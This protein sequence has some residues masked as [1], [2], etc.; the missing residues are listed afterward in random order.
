MGILNIVL[1]SSSKVAVPICDYLVKFHDLKNVITGPDKPKGRGRT[2]TANEFATY[3]ASRGLAVHKPANDSELDTLIESIKPDLVVT[4][5]YGRLIKKHQ[6]S[7]PEKGWINVHFSVLPKWRGAAPVQFSILNGDETSGITVF[8]LDTGLDTGPV[9]ASLEHD[10]K[11][12][13]TSGELLETLSELAIQPLEESLHKITLG[14]D[15]TPQSA[16]GISLAPKVSKNDGQINWFDSNTSIERRVRALSPW[17]GAWSRLDGK[18]IHIVETEIWQA[19]IDKD[20]LPGSLII[21]SQIIAVCG[22]GALR[23]KRVKPEGKREMSADEWVRGIQNKSN[24]RF[25]SN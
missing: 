15:P 25:E 16:D 12:D 21:A 10:L 20:L 13:E 19:E 1:A 14:I 8:K 4:A 3:C 9:Y 2:L 24:L 5:A 23:L 17:P 22:S 18:Q 7:M 11:G 6:L